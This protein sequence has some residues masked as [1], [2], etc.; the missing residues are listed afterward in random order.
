MRF[1]FTKMHA[2]GNDYILI[3]GFRYPMVLETAAKLARRMSDRHF[4]IGSDGLIFAA[5]SREA[6]LAMR[7]YNADG[8][9]AE[10]CGNGIRQLARFVVEKGIVRVGG[11]R[12]RL[13]IETGAGLRT[14]FLDM[15]AG[16]IQQISV[17]M[18]EPIL[19]PEM[20]P[21][22]AMM[23]KNG[24]SQV[25]ISVHG[26][27]MLFLPVSMG[28]PH[29]VTYVDSVEDWNVE[30]YGKPVENKT[31]LF[32]KRTNVE[33]IEVLNDREI[34]MRVWER[35]SGETLACGTGACAS[36]VASALLGRTGREVTVRL[37]GGELKVSWED[38]N[39]VIMTGNSVTVFEGEAE[40]R[41]FLED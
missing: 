34:R 14:V 41:D 2:L 37:L 16:G 25:E 11:Q 35:G 8:S 23:G 30:R 22:K 13:T 38:N 12:I 18:G 31:D 39:R 32:P 33:F 27:D 10:M 1:S 17:D 24:Y 15:T 5:P 40:S 20:I 3:D 7:M 26:K 28:N 4:G 9:E 19:E 29:A 6:D 21:C 36:V